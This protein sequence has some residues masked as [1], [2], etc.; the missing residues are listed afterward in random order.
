MKIVVTA[1]TGAREEKIEK[2]S[3]TEYT[4]WVKEQPVEGRAN[5]AI[6]KALAGYFKIPSSRIRIVIGQTTKKKIVEIV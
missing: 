4:V 6:L 1:K 3:E 5:Y 2:I